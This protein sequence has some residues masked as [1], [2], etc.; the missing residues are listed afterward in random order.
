ML[1]FIILLLSLLSSFFAP[2]WMA[3]PIAFVVCILLARSGRQAF[4]TSFSAV[5][6]C[7]LLLI[8]FTLFTRQHLLLDRMTNLFSLPHPGLVVVLSACIGGLFSGLAG[9]S[10]RLVRAIFQVTVPKV[11]E[12]P[13]FVLPEF[14]LN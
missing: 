1:Y 2:W 11:K 5:F 4:W 13:M 12:K 10:G 6:T 3:G 8:F 14:D 9:L 7:W